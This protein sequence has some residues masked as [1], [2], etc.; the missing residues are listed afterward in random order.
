MNGEKKRVR[1][2]EAVRKEGQSANVFRSP[3]LP[4]C[5][6]GAECSI[7]GGAP[8][9]R[10]AAKIDSNVIG[11]GL[12][13]VI[14]SSSATCSSRISYSQRR[15]TSIFCSRVSISLS[16]TCWGF[17]NV[18]AGSVRP[19]F[20]FNAAVL[21]ELRLALLLLIVFGSFL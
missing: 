1:G 10:S 20:D 2:F 9:L 13:A 12:G 17:L 16:T 14:P 15:R 19:F 21:S 8:K 5:L 18:A 4:P 11:C 6:V 3:Q 7:S